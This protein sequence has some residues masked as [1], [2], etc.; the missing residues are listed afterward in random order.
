MTHEQ[1]PTQELQLFSKS[2][3]RKLLLIVGLSV[4]VYGVLLFYG[5]ASL[6]IETLG[7]IPFD[8]VFYSLILS[9]VSFGVRAIRWQ[10][11]LFLV[12]A[13]VPLGESALI[14]LAGFAM[15]ITPAK[16]GEVLKSLMLK[17]SRDIPVA[18]SAPIVLAERVTDLAGLLVLGGI[19]LLGLPSMLPAAVLTFA[20]VLLLFL[21]FVSERVG[22]WIIARLAWA[23]PIERFRDK[24]EAAYLMLVRILRVRSFIVALALSVLAWGLHCLCIAVLSWG[25]HPEVSLSSALIAYSAPLLAGTLALV[26]GGLGITE[27]S[28]AGTLRVLSGGAM[29]ISVASAL[30][31]LVRLVTFWL[32]IF[33]GFVA[34]LVWQARRG[35][36]KHDQR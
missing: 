34:L 36:R 11:Y 22:M 1:A 5:D 20:C 2:L 21:L 35:F 33:L 7:S 4:L 30:T 14:F 16:M 31:I 8:V 23:R 15:S 6:I 9:L 27:A 18:V 25:M 12:G 29:S 24:L 26:P 28:M 19:G 32:A 3:S 10:Y 17:E 13:K